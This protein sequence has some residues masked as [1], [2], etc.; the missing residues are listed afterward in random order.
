MLLLVDPPVP[1]Y[2]GP[3]T[4]AFASEP[5]MQLRS[6]TL[7]PQRAQLNLAPS[8]S[9]TCSFEADSP[10]AGPRSQ[11]LESC[12]S[13]GLTSITTSTSYGDSAGAVARFAPSFS[14]LQAPSGRTSSGHM[15][16]F[17]F[18]L[19]MPCPPKVATSPVLRKLSENRI[20]TGV[21]V[22]NA[23]GNAPQAAVA[24]AGTS[25]GGGSAASGIRPD[26]M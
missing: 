16:S 19:R 23:G 12:M 4:A 3:Q 26:T 13:A 10:G 18:T 14:L 5:G 25:Q 17:H 24:A 6:G 15:G 8:P 2:T 1:L 11:G 9:C 21:V 20:S 22:M 7:N